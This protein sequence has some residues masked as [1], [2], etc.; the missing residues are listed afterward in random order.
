MLLSNGFYA[1]QMNGI[2]PFYNKIESISRFYMPTTKMTQPTTT[3]ATIST[4]QQN[5]KAAANAS[6]S[7]S[8]TANAINQQES[9]R[10]EYKNNTMTKDVIEA[11]QLK[12]VGIADSV[13]SLTEW[14][15]ELNKTFLPTPYSVLVAKQVNTAYCMDKLCDL[16]CKF[17]K[18][19]NHSFFEISP[20]I[21][22]PLFELI[23]DEPFPEEKYRLKEGDTEYVIPK[24]ADEDKPIS[25]DLDIYYDRLMHYDDIDL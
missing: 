11:N 3:S 17:G 18:E 9:V 22:K 13:A 1:A 19:L 5:A 14:I 6:A 12:H 7:A 15:T 24:A 20:D 4:A 2:Q 23:P 21:I 25:I 16:L 10:Q 8:A